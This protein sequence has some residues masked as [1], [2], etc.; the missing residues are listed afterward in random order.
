MILFLVVGSILCA[1]WITSMGQQMNAGSIILHFLAMSAWLAVIFFSDALEVSYSL[2]R[3]KDIDQF[4]ET[5]GSILKQMHDNEDTVYE[6]REWLVTLMIVLI[7]V[8]VDFDHIYV[9]FPHP[10]KGDW[11]HF[12]IVQLQDQYAWLPIRTTTIFSIL[13]TTFPVLWLAQGPSK[14]IARRFP[15]RMVDAGSLVWLFV[16][17]PVGW[18]T[19]F[20]RLN[21]PSALI[22]H[23]WERIAG[24]KVDANLRASDQHYYLTSIQRYGYALH[25]IQMR[26][27]VG[28][29]GEATIEERLV[30]YVIT[31][32]CNVFDRRLSFS[33]AKPCTFEQV[34]AKAY[35]ME[36]IEEIGS[37][38]DTQAILETLDSIADKTKTVPESLAKEEIK[39]A[40]HVIPISDE[41]D[42]NQMRYRTSPLEEE[43]TAPAPAP[44]S[45]SAK[46]PDEMKLVHYRIDTGGSI[47]TGDKAFALVVEFKATWSG[48]AFDMIP[49]GPDFFY[50]I[51]DCPCKRYRL[52]VDTTG[53]C[54][55]RPSGVGANATCGSDPHWGERD[56][57]Q[58]SF[59]MDPGSPNGIHCNLE[60]AFP[61]ITYELSWKWTSKVA[62]NDVDGPCH[63]DA[64][65]AEKPQ[66][67]APP[68]PPISTPEIPPP[69]PK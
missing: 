53:D 63:P 65:P 20:L 62:K 38:E 56:R 23:S 54:E 59:D 44:G 39:A 34:T 41:K 19:D 40:I 29:S 69:P 16:V 55:L 18:I 12:V 5:T 64:K 35:W 25:D 68:P 3:H 50:M 15:Q 42:P 1:T 8:I 32:P 22:A 48:G 49:G 28:S 37:P 9:P 31:R 46:A 21:G 24:L 27:T 4:G 47:P 67:V 10:L 33:R 17:R 36:V 58:R 57:L 60:Y 2:L 66:A 30:Y 52:T 13:F 45:A 11:F 43:S 7:T 61:G 51:I 6:G 26:V 14:K